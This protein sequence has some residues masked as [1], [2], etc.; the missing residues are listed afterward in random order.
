MPNDFQSLGFTKNHGPNIQK[1][2]SQKSKHPKS[3]SYPTSKMSKRLPGPS[4]TVPRAVPPTAAWPPCRRPAAAGHRGRHQVGPVD[5]A[6]DHQG[7]PRD[8]DHVEVKRLGMWR[9]WE[10]SENFWGDWLFCWSVG[11]CKRHVCY[12]MVFV[13]P[14][15]TGWSWRTKCWTRA[16]LHMVLWH[17]KSMELSNRIVHMFDLMVR[18]PSRT[19]KNTNQLWMT[20]KVGALAIARLWTMWRLRWLLWPLWHGRAWRHQLLRKISWKNVSN[21]G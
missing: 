20:S 11:G 1:Q 19:G 9:C 5:R 21:V 8:Q 16:V 18:R 2:N 15:K 12:R 10:M 14:K 4:A 17:L 13:W 7:H 6:V 3:K